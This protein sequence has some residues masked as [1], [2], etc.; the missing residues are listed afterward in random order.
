MATIILQSEIEKRQGIRYQFDSSSQPIG[1]GGMGRVFEGVCVNERTGAVRPVAIKFM[2]DDLPESA[3]ER[4][5]REA[6]IQLRN[7]NLIEM[8]GFIDIE[9]KYPDGFVRHHYHI[10]SELLNGVSLSDLMNGKVKGRDGQDIP[11]AVKMLQDYK[12]DPEHFAKTVVINVLSGLMALHDAGYIHRDIDPSNIMITDDGHIKLI[13]FGIAKQINL[14]TTGDRALTEAGKFMGKYQ[15]AAPELILGDINHQ[16]QTTDIYAVGILLYQ[17]IVGNPPFEGTRLEMMDMQLK[18]KLPLNKIKDKGLR[19][20]IQTATEKK[21]ELRYPTSAQMRAAME[22][23]NGAK[24]GVSPK[25]MYIIGAAILSLLVV[26]GCVG[27]YVLDKQKTAKAEAEAAR[28]EQQQVEIRASVESALDNA[29]R[30]YTMGMSQE[31]EDN[32]EKSLMEAYTEYDNVLRILAANPLPDFKIEDIE[33]K[34]QQLN[35]ALDSAV[36]E[37]NQQAELLVSLEENQL[38]D[39]YKKRSENIV[40]FK[41]DEK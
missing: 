2:F 11:F 1:E 25:R 24:R 29:G 37:L 35:V 20:I 10:I 14:L 34:K 38:A 41:N 16:N 12:N 22:N 3:I 21:Q 40:K 27:W 8:L 18:K 31:N 6:A 36:S 23:I 9:E 13:D 33:I 5:R 32:Y 26:L 7:D 28:I 30:L 15:Y 19:S 17:C 4:A 39:Q